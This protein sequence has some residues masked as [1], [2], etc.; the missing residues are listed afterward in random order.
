VSLKTARQKREE[1]AKGVGSGTHKQAAKAA[2][3]AETA[4]LKKIPGQKFNKLR[5]VEKCYASATA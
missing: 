5:K 4:G 1:V 3:R 2:A